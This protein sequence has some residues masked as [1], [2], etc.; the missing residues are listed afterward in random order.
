MKRTAAILN[1]VNIFNVQC[2]NA[3]H[4]DIIILAISLHLLGKQL[5][6][7]QFQRL[8]SRLLALLPVWR[9]MMLEAL[10]A[11]MQP[12]FLSDSAQIRA[13]GAWA[14][15]LLVRATKLTFCPCAVWLLTA[16]WGEAHRSGNRPA[17]A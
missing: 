17:G 1:T 5:P 14:L 10:V 15:V 2:R 12:R 4:T 16:C 6:L 3:L 7:K 9:V 11:H 8:R 13:L